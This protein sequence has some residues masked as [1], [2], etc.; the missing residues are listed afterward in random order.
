[1]HKIQEKEFTLEDF[2]TEHLLGLEDEPFM[3]SVSSDGTK[4]SPLGL[5]ADVINVLNGC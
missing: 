5:M 2:S 3:V 4:L 1:M